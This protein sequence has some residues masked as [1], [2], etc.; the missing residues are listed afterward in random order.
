MAKREKFDFEEFQRKATERIK[1]GSPLLGTDGVFTPLLKEFLEAAM[2]AEMAEHIES[3]EGPNRRNG[4]GRKRVKSH[5]GTVEIA[6]P[7]DREGT[8]EPVTVPK[9]SNVLSSDLDEVIL[10]LYSQGSSY[11]D[12]SAQMER[13]YGVEVSEATISRVTDRVWPLVQEWRSRPLEAVYPFVWLDAIHFKVRKDG[14]VGPMAVY[15]VVGVDS[16]G[17]KGLLGMYL[18]ETEGAKFWLNVL[19]DLQQ[20]GV[21]DILIACIDNLKGFA[22]AVEAVFPKTQVQLCVVHQIRNSLR[23]VADKDVK[24]FMRDLKQVYRAETREKA[25]GKL[26]DLEEAWAKA[27]P[28]VIE[29]WRRNWDRL[30]GYFQYTDKIRRVI[31][32]TNIIE[33]FHRQLRKATKAKGAFSSEQALV[34]LLFLVQQRITAKWE[35]PLFNWRAILSQLSVTFDDRL[36]LPT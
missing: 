5:L 2:E 35:R 19:T 8:F 18:A 33:G 30:S 31:Y 26:D 20:R 15:C 12:I 7:R 36:R 16:E 10:F 34:K 17:Y 11:Q 22:E 14:R 25:E 23:F 6:P 3:G 1:S 4:H 13:I 29:S 9:R 28:K 27:Y 32:T 21:E 24:A